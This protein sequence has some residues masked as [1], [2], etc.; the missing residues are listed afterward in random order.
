LPDAEVRI[1]PY[2]VYFCSNGG[3]GRERL[4]VLIA[5]LVDRFGLVTIAD[6]E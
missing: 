2:G 4:G 6:W 1:E 5:S 3:A